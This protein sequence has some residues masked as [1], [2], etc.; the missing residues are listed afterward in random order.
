MSYSH[1][2]K[3]LCE[4]PGT[5]DVPGTEESQQIFGAMLDGGIPELELGA[6]LVALATRPASVSMRLGFGATLAARVHSLPLPDGDSHPDL[7]PIVIPAYG[8][9]RTQRNLAP[10]VAL[11]LQHLRIPVLVHG[12]LEGHGGVASAY[13]FRE[14]G[15][16]PCMTLAQAGAAMSRDR[17]A[18]VPTGVIAPGLA[19]LLALHRRLGITGTCLS[20]AGLLDPFNGAGMRVVTSDHAAGLDIMRALL[21]AEGGAGL[22]MQ[23]TEGEAFV[24]PRRRPRIELVRDGASTVLYEPEPSHEEDNEAAEA[25]VGARSTAEWMRRVLAGHAALPQPIINQLACCLYAS[26]HSTDLNQA[27]AIVAVETRSL[28]AA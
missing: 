14:L 9:A 2:I 22:L 24:N 10:L 7:H 20:M 3:A 27:K 17:L 8:G 16:M 13:I 23:G 12:T 26:G 5:G 19:Q 18:F 28:A 6:L 11:I 1:M 25:D 4:E 15:V 21:L